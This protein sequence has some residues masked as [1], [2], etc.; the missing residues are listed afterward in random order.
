MKTSTIMLFLLIFCKINAQQKLPSVTLKNLESSTVTTTTN[1]SEKDKL[2]V[3][4]FWATWCAPCIQELDAINDV[5]ADWKK[6]VN[7]E[8]VAVSVDDAR[9]NK[10]VKPMVNGKGWEYQVLLDTNQ[11]FKR[12]LSIANVPY[13]IIVKNNEIVFVQ[14]GHSPG[15]ENELFEKLKTL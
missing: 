5:Y 11:E 4:S 12:S 1:F 3:F 6:E 10:R 9:T 14:S 15:G 13:L 2:Y 8:V 7:L